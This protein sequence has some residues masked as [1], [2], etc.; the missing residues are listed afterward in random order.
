MN[1]YHAQGSDIQ[2]IHSLVM[3]FPKPKCILQLLTV[4][5][6]THAFQQGGRSCAGA[7][8]PRRKVWTLD[9]RTFSRILC[10]KVP[11]WVKTV[12]LGQEVYYYMV[13]IAYFTFFP[14]K[15]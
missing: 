5:S 15:L 9:L 13:Y 4:V 8:G 1:N 11:F 2:F 14:R 6:I 3:T 12:S 10:K 7:R